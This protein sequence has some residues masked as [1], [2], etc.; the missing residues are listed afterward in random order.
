MMNKTSA[1]D[2]SIQRSAFGGGD[3]P[4]DFLTMLKIFIRPSIVILFFMPALI[5]VLFII[6]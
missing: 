1:P 3:F 5:V 4:P 2:E 6:H